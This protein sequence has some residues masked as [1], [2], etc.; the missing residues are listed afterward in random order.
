V[1][2]RGGD[3]TGESIEE[4][5][6]GGSNAGRTIVFDAVAIVGDRSPRSLAALDDMVN[7]AGVAVELVG[8]RRGNLLPGAVG[9]QPIRLELVPS[10]M[11]ACRPG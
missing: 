9:R 6:T 3:V 8:I 5:K 11:P 2:R 7:H 4:T 1:R 10:P